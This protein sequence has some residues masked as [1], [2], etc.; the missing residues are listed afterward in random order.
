MFRLARR[1]P[2]SRN[3]RRIMGSARRCL[4]GPPSVAR[5]LD[6]R[7]GSREVRDRDGAAALPGVPR[8]RAPVLLRGGDRA[9]VLPGQPGRPA[10]TQLRRRGLLRGG[11]AGRMGLGPVPAGP[12]RQER[13]GDDFQGRQ[14][15][16]RSE[17]RRVGKECRS[18]W[19]TYVEKKKKSIWSETKM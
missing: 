2:G 19:A 8:H 17:E 9:P 12:L 18:R 7:G 13:P 6:E 4:V 10:R 16:G 5:W 11:D 14:C 15:R 3:V 1:S